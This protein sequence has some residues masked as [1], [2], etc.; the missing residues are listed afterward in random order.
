MA[1]R[2][3]AWLVWALLAGSLVFWGLRL[4]APSPGLPDQVRTVGADQ[5]ARGDILRLFANPSA[6]ADAA[7][8]AQQ[9]AAAS[10]MRLLG[11]V[12]GLSGGER[13]WAMLAVDG[14]PARMFAVGA[15]VVTGW[16]VQSVSQRQVEVGP[17]GGAPVAVLDLP[18]PPAPQTG[19]LRAPAGA[20]VSAAPGAVIP[21]PPVPPVV[22]QPT[23]P[24]GLTVPP[25]GVPVLEG[26]AAQPVGDQPQATLR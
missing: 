20:A 17:P 23:A 14:L 16:V 24:P 6:G 12:A 3:T 9:S 10:R 2:T 4:G 19:E 25:P 26:Q 15:E 1:A 13:G 5:S 8:P 11:V 22:G 7:A 21:A 18:L